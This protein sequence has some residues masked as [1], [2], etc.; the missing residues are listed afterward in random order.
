MTVGLG[1]RPGL[2]EVAVTVRV[3]FSLA[4]PEAMPDKVT[5][6]SPASSLIVRLL[7]GAS[8][9]GSLRALTVTVKVRLTTLLIVPPSFT[10]TVTIAVPL[11][12]ATGVKVK[13]PVA[14]G[15]V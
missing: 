14:L 5:D 6:C 9:G 13:L 15:L 4:A 10:V 3:W 1:M 7:S 11:A 2:L 8:V 12:L